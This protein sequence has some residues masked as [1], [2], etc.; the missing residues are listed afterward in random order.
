MLARSSAARALVCPRLVAVRYGA[1]ALQSSCRF[2][3]R[4][5]VFWSQ[6]L[7]VSRSFDNIFGA[8]WLGI[9]SSWRSVGSAQIELL[10]SLLP[11]DV[12]FHSLAV[13]DIMKISIAHEL[14]VLTLR[15]KNDDILVTK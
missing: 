2:D 7:Y 5:W 8:R 3:S 4:S 9:Y 11:M 15:A 14:V 1:C 12:V 10:A 6:V 13:Q